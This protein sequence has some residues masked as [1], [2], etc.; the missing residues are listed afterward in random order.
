[1]TIA[2]MYGLHFSVGTEE[3]ETN[4]SKDNQCHGQDL[5]TVTQMHRLTYKYAKG[6]Q[7]DG[8]INSQIGRHRQTK[9]QSVCPVTYYRK[10]MDLQCMS[11]GSQ[12]INWC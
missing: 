5:N 9:K 7:M 2:V 1:M 10:C 11:A 6:G 8:S 4:F 12:I 3:Q